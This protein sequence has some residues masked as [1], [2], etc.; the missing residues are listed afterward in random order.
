M[1]F[2][3]PTSRAALERDPQKAGQAMESLLLQRMLSSCNLMGKSHAPGAGMRSDLFV[4]TLADAVTKSGGLGLASEFA[5]KGV[6]PGGTPDESAK[7]I[8][9][10]NPPNS[11]GDLETQLIQRQPR[12][13]GTTNAT[14]NTLGEP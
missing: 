11:G 6:A 12:L 5:G 1:T 2:L 10:V 7:N 3:D 4:E 14:D 8:L 13:I 9:T